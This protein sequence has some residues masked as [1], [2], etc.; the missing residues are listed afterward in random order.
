MPTETLETDVV[1]PDSDQ[2]R[3]GGEYEYPDEPEAGEEGIP[4][5]VG[6]MKEAD[7]E[8]TEKP[9]VADVEDSRESE[10]ESVEDFSASE[11]YDRLLGYA[12]RLGMSESEARGYEP[13][14]LEGV[15]WGITREARVSEAE[16]GAPPAPAE[17]PHP[18]QPE[19]AAA[20][21]QYEYAF[22]PD[23]D[24]ED[25][26]PT[27]RGVGKGLEGAV[28][29]FND[30]FIQG[31][32]AMQQIVAKQ[33]QMERFIQGLQA[34]VVEEQCDAF[35]AQLGDEY[36]DDLGEGRTRELPRNSD[37]LRMRGE[38]IQEAETRAAGL[39]AR[40][41]SV[42]GTEKLLAHAHRAVFSDRTKTTARKEIEQDVQ[43]RRGQAM[44][45]P[46]RRSKVPATGLD[47]AVAA[48]VQFEREH[49]AEAEETSE[50]DA[51]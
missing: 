3:V 48:A 31:E 1:T 39:R 46:A 13:R 50:M 25:L 34:S 11:D 5:D 22:K 38:I 29:H 24:P 40:N 28:G 35:F 51:Y 16:R 47:A 23:G 17:R 45:R 14:M 36:K 4:S 7:A 30:R 8:T 12:A 44:S 20:P 33:Q 43:K 37:A 27:L 41:Q 6:E 49:G 21:P 10:P 2:E 42:P 18:G 32:R 9:E 26:E 15:L 19:R